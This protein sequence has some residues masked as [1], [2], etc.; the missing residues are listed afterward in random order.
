[1]ERIAPKP[2]PALYAAIGV[3]TVAVFVGDLATPLGIA[4]WIGYLVPLILTF[5]T[6]KPRMPIWVAFLISILVVVCFFTDANNQFRNLSRLNRSLGAVTIWV[7]AYGSMLSIQNRIR[8]RRHEWLQTA[9][10]ELNVRMSGEQSVGELA[11][12]VTRYLADLLGA[13]SGAM[14]VDEAGIYH[15]QGGYAIPTGGAIPNSVRPGEGALGQAITEKRPICLRDVPSNYVS[16]GS[17]LGATAPRTILV[18]PFVEDNHVEGVLE[19][20]LLAPTHELD[21]EL[22]SH[23]SEPVA[24]AVRTAKYRARLQELHEETQRQNEELQVQA[25]ELRA[26]N[27]ELE[28]HTQALRESQAQLEMQQ[29]ELEQ[30]NQRLEEQTNALQK[31]SRELE[32][33]AREVEQA[34]RY[35]S[36][37]L[38]NMSHELRTPLNSS[39][40]LAR[41]LAENRG[42]N[43]TEEQVKYAT[44][45]HSA[46]TDLL[47]LIN[48]I[49]DLSKIEAGRMDVRLEVVSVVELSERLHRL[50]S[51]LADHKGLT[52]ICHTQEAPDT[53]Y[54]DAQRLEQ[55]LKNLISNAIKFTEKGSCRLVIR[56]ERERVVFEVVDTGI[57]V[58]PEHQE[59]IFEAFRQ[60]DSTT[61]RKYGGTGLGL[62]ITKQIVQM[63]GGSV[64]V[65]SNP[66]Q[67][68]TFRVDLP[69]DFA[70]PETLRTS[71]AVPEASVSVG[72]LATPFEPPILDDRLALNEGED[73]ILIIEDDASFARILQNL[74]TE[75]DFRTLVANTADEGLALATRYMPRAILLDL[76]LPDAS[77]LLVLDQ[78]KGSGRTRHIPVHVVSASDHSE[79]ALSLGAVAYLTKPVNRDDLVHAF[80]TLR[81]RLSQSVRKVLVVED[82]PVQRE[83]LCLLL[84][85]SQITAEGVDSA[86]KCLERLR[87]T[88][89]DCLVLD[90]SL[91]DADGFALLE[92]MS[93]DDDQPFPPVVV[94]TG[95]DLTSDE[96]TRLRRY[97]SSIIVK[98]AK[99][100]E[101]LLD[102][103]TLFLHQVVADLPSDRQRLLE[104]VRGREDA[105]RDRTIL[106]VE[107]DVRNIFA[108]TSL[109]EPR[110]AKVRIA[111][112]GREALEVIDEA[113]LIPKPEIDLILMDVMMPEMDGLTATREIRRREGWK[114]VPII[115]L[116]AKAM[117]NDQQECLAAGASDYMAKP[118]DVDRLFSLVRVWLPK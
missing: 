103:V 60:G 49:L 89:F 8:L 31:S 117:K 97:S 20:G 110:G 43:L 67:G 32:Q 52:F 66:G 14:F 70:Y 35:K 81:D 93:Q 80:D 2:S 114:K 51:P 100:P 17:G 77:G 104:S 37:F 88:T 56:K 90:L 86:E 72:T 62:A 41:L 68:S 111:R 107:D 7:M 69:M 48:D 85:T 16:I 102:E 54:T 87:E 39:L 53:I 9:T 1:M 118:L 59:E 108:L 82:D 19:L 61:S 23:I 50:F 5:F 74:A 24:V 84:G 78:L 10:N 25:E 33:R 115:A 26:S 40:I 98:G 38:A 46:G 34:S 6:W 95:R 83:S 45:I 76:G 92:E 71:V 3:T 112:N 113:R 29:G 4:I 18:A 94:Y 28:E 65:E 105:L 75:F 13:A 15:R 63:L 22:F 64:G 47:T 30:A 12:N 91:G 106:I 73:C 96:E 58:R 99:S 21:L 57:G 101:R 79:T 116:T 11:T 27:E 109:L 44:T 55:V 42:G 36:D